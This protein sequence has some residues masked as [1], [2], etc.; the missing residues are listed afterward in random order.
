MFSTLAKPDH[1]LKKLIV[2]DT[3]MTSSAIFELC[4]VLQENQT[5]RIL[6]I[7]DNRLKDDN[8]AKILC[9][10]IKQNTTLCTLN[11]QNAFRNLGTD[12]IDLIEAQLKDNVSPCCFPSTVIA[13]YE[14]SHERKRPY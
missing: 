11:Y 7:S 14:S 12:E 5:L 10:A 13:L 4:K 3:R 1:T 9:V 2:S 6:D 8:A